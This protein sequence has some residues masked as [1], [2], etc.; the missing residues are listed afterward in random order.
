MQGWARGPGGI[1]GGQLRAGRKSVHPFPFSSPPSAL[2]SWQDPGQRSSLCLAAA[3]AGVRGAGRRPGRRGPPAG[4]L[5]VKEVITEIRDPMGIQGF[6]PQDSAPA[7][8][9]TLHKAPHP[10]QPSPCL[11]PVLPPAPGNPAA[12]GAAKSLQAG[13][14]PAQWGLIPGPAAPQ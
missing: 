9:F 1:S 4:C 12:P 10:P 11:Q 2:S 7:P 6:Q 3:L 13:A 5:S 8:S 14:E